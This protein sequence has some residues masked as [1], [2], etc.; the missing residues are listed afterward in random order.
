MREKITI[1]LSRELAAWLEMAAAKR[2]V[3]QG[4]FVRDQLEKAMS[5][6]IVHS[7]MRVAGSVRGPK[8]L[9]AR[10]GFFRADLCLIRMSELHPRYSVITV[11]SAD[12][13]IY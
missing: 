8:N 12:F 7:F 4:K 3:S 9:S 13:R 10:K 5:N 2:G 1:R 6:S 11:D